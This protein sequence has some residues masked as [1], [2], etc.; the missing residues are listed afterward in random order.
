MGVRTAE[1]YHGQL[2]A[3]LPPG[4]AW[5][6][7]LN[8]QVDAM[9]AV[10]A[11]ELAREDLRVADLL[12]ESEPDTVRELVP[13]WERVMKL[14]DPCLGEAPTFDD[15]QLAVRRRLVEVGGQ[16]AAYFVELA[17]SLGYTQARVVEHRAPRFGRSR[18]GASHFGTW[19]AQFMWTLET[20]PRLRL[21]RRFGASYWGQRFGM[22][23]SGAL[24]CVIRRSAPAHTLEFIQYG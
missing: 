14:P 21:G 5:D 1:D 24:E 23:P 9:L 12:T 7:E 18:F 6:R 3:L 11:Q 22:N 15:R 10:A 2:R 13:D 17:F 20:G 8:P 4:P 19:T 16:A